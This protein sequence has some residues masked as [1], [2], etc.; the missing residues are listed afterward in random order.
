[1]GEPVFNPAV[2][3]LPFSYPSPFAPGACEGFAKG[4]GDPKAVLA[5]PE[6]V[7]EVKWDGDRRTMHIGGDFDR[8]YLY[9]RKTGVNGNF[10]EKALNV[11]HIWQGALARAKEMGLGYTVLDG[12]IIVPG[13]EGVGSSRVTK[14]MGAV[15][16]EAVKRASLGLRAQYVVFDAPYL[17]G[18]DIRALPYDERRERVTRLVASLFGEEAAMPV[19]PDAIRA[20]PR[21]S[22]AAVGVA[23]HGEDKDAFLRQSLNLGYEGVVLKKRSA[24]YGKAWIKVKGVWTV[25][26]VIKGFTE[27]KEETKKKGE[28]EKT[29]SKFAGQVGAVVFGVMKGG[30]LVEVGQASGMPDDLRKAFTDNPGGYV[31]RC[32]EIKNNGWTGEALRHPRFVTFRDDLIAQHCTFEKLMTDLAWAKANAEL[33]A[34]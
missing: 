1:M 7:E 8:V 31:G 10:P 18:E 2:L 30:E 13:T 17:N 14:V 32:V 9:S 21:R 12:E 3:T 19:G 25:D 24:A 11:P 27:A 15:V 28:K 23:V 34:K 22:E 5:S 16:Q 33:V 26:V 4:H 20:W 29:A 6:W